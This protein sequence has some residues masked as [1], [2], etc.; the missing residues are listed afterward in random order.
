MVIRFKSIKQAKNLNFCFQCAEPEAIANA[1]VVRNGNKASHTCDV[2]FCFVNERTRTI[3]STCE[4]SPFLIGL[5]K[6]T[7]LS[8]ISPFESSVFDDYCIAS[9]HF[10][11]KLSHFNSEPFTTYIFVPSLEPFESLNKKN[12]SKSNYRS[13]S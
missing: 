9:C 3:Q 10:L 2:G 7:V 8:V 4:V 11:F 5:L 12:S 13:R 1:S 6:T